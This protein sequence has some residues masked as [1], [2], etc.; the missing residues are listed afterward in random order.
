MTDRFASSNLDLS[1]LPPPAV[2]KGVEYEAILAER[3]ARFKQ[4]WPDFDVDALETDPAKVLQEADAYREM[5]AKAAINDAARATMIS[6]A[7]GSDLENLAAFYGITRLVITPATDS[8]PAVMESDADLR[9]RVKL[10]PEA[11][12]YAGMTGGG[13]KALARRVAPSVKDV[14]TIKRPGGRVDVILLGRDGNGAV[15]ADVV[16]SVYHAFQDDE[17]TQ[18]TDI[19]T[20]RSAAITTYDVPLTLRVRRGPDPA[21]VKAAAEAA[22]RAY[23]LSRHRVGAIAYRNM[24]EAAAAVGGVENAIVGIDDVTPGADGAAWLGTLTTNVEVVD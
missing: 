14:G 16:T 4:L 1:L 19:V 23:A 24:L 12:P 22:L 13:Y 7:V 11:L 20:V 21:S 3:L 15:P 6:F 2:I 17:A 8:A 10:A 5:L 18:L 9:Q